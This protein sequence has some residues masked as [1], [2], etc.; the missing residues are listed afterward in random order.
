MEEEKNLKVNPPFVPQACRREL[1]VRFP[2]ETELSTFQV[3]RFGSWS[4][5]QEV[6]GK[7]LAEIEYFPK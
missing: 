3:P 2:G 4:L 1:R 7:C 6:D 5:P